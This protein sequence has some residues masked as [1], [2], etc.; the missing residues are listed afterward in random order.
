M[1]ISNKHERP[2]HK[3]CVE[4]NEDPKDDWK[5]MFGTPDIYTHAS[6]FLWIQSQYDMFVLERVFHISYVTEGETTFTLSECL[7]NQKV[8]VDLT[9]SFLL[10]KVLYPLAE[11]GHS[12]WSN[13]C[14]WYESL[15]RSNMDF[16]D[17]Q[18]AAIGGQQLTIQEA[19]EKLVF[20]D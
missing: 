20:D 9:R 17:Q 13:A 7:P 2:P 8:A 19:V 6:K 15:M 5:C 11:K 1:K 10:Q 4:A 18:R 3:K 12:V 14:L 16:S